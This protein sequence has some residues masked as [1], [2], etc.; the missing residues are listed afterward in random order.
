[1]FRIVKSGRFKLCAEPI[2]FNNRRQEDRR[3]FN[4]WCVQRVVFE[5]DEQYQEVDYR[6]PRFLYAGEE[7]LRRVTELC[8]SYSGEFIVTQQLVN[9]VS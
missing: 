9:P 6:H 2:N 1:M 7:V 8:D 3:E 5:R 4:Q